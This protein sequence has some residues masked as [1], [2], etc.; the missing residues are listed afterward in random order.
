MR[1]FW[2]LCGGLLMCAG[3]GCRSADE[4][5][6]GEVGR[7]NWSRAVGI[8]G[9][10]AVLNAFVGERNKDDISVPV[11]DSD[12]ERISRLP[13]IR[14]V[15]IYKVGIGG[16]VS[17]GGIGHLRRLPDLRLLHVARE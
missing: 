10:E 4:N 3:P 12:L 13:E 7:K 11:R 5:A 6:S 17:A 14:F 8:R 9:D 15:R 2:F 16:A 1:S